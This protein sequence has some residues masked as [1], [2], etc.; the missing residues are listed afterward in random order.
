[1][2]VCKVE[3]CD[4]GGRMT[5]G[6]CRMHYNRWHRH[7]T[8]TAGR[9]MWAGT[10][11]TFEGCGRE[12]AAQ[13]LCY[14]HLAQQK[15]GIELVP[16]N[17]NHGHAAKR[18]PTYISWQCMKNRCYNKKEKKYELY[19]GRGITI[20]DR[21]MESFSAFLE[22]MGERPAG[23]TLDRI[24]VN[25][26]YEIGNCRWATVKEQNANRRF[27]KD[28][29]KKSEKD[30]NLIEGINKELKKVRAEEKACGVRIKELLIARDALSGKKKT[31]TV[32]KSTP[33][34]TPSVGVDA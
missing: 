14:G 33:V 2:N 12:K 31:K 7:G 9:D 16:L 19:G 28:K 15:R 30:M 18:S 8:L 22:D 23:M 20:C 26:N 11:C 1:M 32:R 3:D 10:V 24:D 25:G 5:L 4:R 13:G 34:S 27:G 6:L 17:I 29:N 21:W